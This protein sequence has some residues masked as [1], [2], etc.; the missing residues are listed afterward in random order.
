MAWLQLTS[1]VQLLE[2]INSSSIKPQLFFKHS[3]RCIISKM[4]L[5]EFERS[6]VIKSGLADFYLLDLLNYRSISNEISE[7]LNIIH[8]SPQAIILFENKVLYSETHERIDGKKVQVI[9]DTI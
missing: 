5:Q 9:L 2:A 3:T 8:Q 1:P 7:R 4:A 6:G